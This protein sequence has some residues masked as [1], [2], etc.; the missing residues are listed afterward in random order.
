[1]ARIIVSEHGWILYDVEY[2]ITYMLPKNFA[3]M[4]K[5]EQEVAVGEGERDIAEAIRKRVQSSIEGK[6]MAM[7]EEYLGNDRYSMFAET[8]TEKE[9][10]RKMEAADSYAKYCYE[11][12]LKAGAPQEFVDFIK[13]ENRY[14]S[15]CFY[16][17]AHSLQRSIPE[18]VMLPYRQLQELHQLFDLSSVQDMSVQDASFLDYRENITRS[19]EKD[20]NINAACAVVD[21]TFYDGNT[22]RIGFVSWICAQEIVGYLKTFNEGHAAI[23]LEKY[24]HR[25]KTLAVPGYNPELSYTKISEEDFENV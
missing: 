22:V 24:I 4:S 3:S 19:I 7:S 13:R 5:A 17:Y 25:C 9:E 15:G 12:A 11:K 14:S 2:A 6:K 23:R 18:M 16:K 1:M 20:R 10:R 8:A 21:I